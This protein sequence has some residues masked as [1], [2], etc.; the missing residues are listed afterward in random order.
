MYEQLSIFD[1][2]PAEAVK[3]GDWVTEHGPVIPH[4][5]RPSFIGRLVVLDKS[6]VSHE[7]FEVG[8][9]VDY[10][11]CRGH[12]RSVV[13]IG[14]NHMN[15]IDH[16]EQPS[17]YHGEIYELSPKQWDSEGHRWVPKPGKGVSK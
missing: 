13:Q 11:E 6:T 7:W 12:M 3:M 2:V 17:I 15:Y 10:I 9:L 5:M 8:R 1:L 16:Y 4:I 14:K